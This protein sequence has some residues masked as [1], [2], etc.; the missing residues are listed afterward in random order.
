MSDVKRWDIFEAEFNGPLDGN[1]FYEVEF[2]AEF[3]H[4][5]TTLT[6]RGFYDGNGVYKVRCMPL[7]TGE[8]EFVTSSDRSELHGKK[9]SFKCVEADSRNRG[10]VHV[11]NEYHLQY[12]DGSPHLS[13]GTTCYAWVHQPVK[14]QEQTL[15][16]M[17][18][19][20]FNKL[21]MCVF[22]KHYEFNQNEPEIFPC[23]KKKNG[24]LD[25]H[26]PNPEFYKNFEKRVGQLR[27]MDIQADIILLHPYDKWGFAGMSSYGNDKYLQYAVSRLS[28][29]SNVW[30]SMANEWDLMRNLQVQD[31]DRMSKLVSDTDPYGHMLGIH[32]CGTWYDHNKEWITHQSIQ[33][34]AVEKTYEWREK[35]R[36]PVVND[37]CKYEGNIHTGWGGITPQRMTLNF[38]VTMIYGG[39]CGHGETY[40]HPK[41]ILWWSK[42]GVLHGESPAR[43]AFL[44]K[45]M[46][47]APPYL[48]ATH[49]LGTNCLTSEKNDYYLRY[50][51]GDDQ[52]A[53][54][55][56]HLPSDMR[57][58]CDVI[59]T[60]NMT[61]TPV[62]G[63]FSGRC[64]VRFESAPY[65]A[66]RFIAK[67][68]DHIRSQ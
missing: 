57:F 38:W 45:I 9:G 5:K 39:Y 19:G 28:A 51:G 27:D 67:Q 13:F 34:Y 4:E 66:L 14:L 35:C 41:D 46:E 3:K 11:H 56:L 29:Y 17:K 63:E 62:E 32:N 65:Q 55:W 31:W 21:R 40:E 2:T 6:A 24:E 54:V 60:W 37:E 64:H 18:A 26:R 16:T 36:K 47:E 12:A 52:H 42:G 10:P 44:R 25:L 8:W 7:H 15:E 61:I 20:P 30:W 43:I 50:C 53:L 1:P 23:E 59:D 58:K 33:S 48:R 68:A 22:P 49:M